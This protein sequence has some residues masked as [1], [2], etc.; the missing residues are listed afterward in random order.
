MLSS[1]FEKGKGEFWWNITPLGWHCRYKG[2]SSGHIHFP[3]M[4]HWQYSSCYVHL[5]GGLYSVWRSAKGNRKEQALDEQAW[6]E[7]I[8]CG[9]CLWVHTLEKIGS[10]RVQLPLPTQNPM[11]WG[12]SPVC[13][14]CTHVDVSCLYIFIS[15]C[16]LCT[17]HVPDGV[18]GFCVPCVLEHTFSIGNTWS[19]SFL[20]SQD[21]WEGYYWA[22]L[23]QPSSW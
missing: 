8:L 22:F 1:C 7:C 4:K 18:G 11:A 15:Q 9:K 12:A 14:T 16:S 17:L 10:T 5:F 2:G 6:S 19:F 20:W 21:S 23:G 13:V 3:Y